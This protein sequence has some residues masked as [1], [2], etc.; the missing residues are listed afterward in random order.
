MVTMNTNGIGTAVMSWNSTKRV[1]KQYHVT[2]T[3]EKKKSARS[4]GCA[5]KKF[6]VG[7]PPMYR[8]RG[9]SSKLVTGAP[10]E[11]RC[12]S[13]R[14]ESSPP[15]TLRRRSSVLLFIDMLPLL[16]ASSSLASRRRS[17]N[18]SEAAMRWP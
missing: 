1:K 13:S 3:K 6:R 2:P 12:R 7:A 14:S 4:A 15:S 11:S 10:P 16:R 9:E 8:F 18:T 5:G 17:A